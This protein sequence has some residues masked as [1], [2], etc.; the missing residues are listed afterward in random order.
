MGQGRMVL[1]STETP[2][3][4]GRDEILTYLQ[5]LVFQKEL[6]VKFYSFLNCFMLQGFRSGH[7]DLYVVLKGDRSSISDLCRA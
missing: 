2:S 3:T 6:H 5:Y 7:S 1:I 4:R